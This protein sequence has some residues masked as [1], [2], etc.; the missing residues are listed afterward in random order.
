MAPCSFVTYIP[1]PKSSFQLK[2]CIASLQ[3]EWHSAQNCSKPAP[4][5][6][7]LSYWENIFPLT[8][9]VARA[10]AY[11]AI[12]TTKHLFPSCISYAQDRSDNTIVLPE[13]GLNKISIFYGLFVDHRPSQK[14]FR[15]HKG[16][17]K[18]AGK[19]SYQLWFLT[20]TVSHI[21]SSM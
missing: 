20:M 18:V 5:T 15:L 19:S 7:L 1:M 12:P 8:I 11:N 10:F 9:F 13:V 21:D 4:V 16:L 17:S 6:S 14:Q 2:N 3:A